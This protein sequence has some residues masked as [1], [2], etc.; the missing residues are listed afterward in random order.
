MRIAI[1][2]HG[3]KLNRAESDQLAQALVRAGHDVVTIEEDPD[4]YILNTCT[5]T[6]V[7]DSKARQALR[8]ARRRVP[9]VMTLP[10]GC[11]A[12]RAAGELLGIEGVARVVGGVN[13]QQVL[14]AL[15]EM[16]K[17]ICPRDGL[18]VLAEMKERQH[19]RTRAFIK[20]QSG[21]RHACS[22]CIVRCIKGS[23]VS[24]PVESV[25]AQVRER[26]SEGYREVV[27]TGTQPGSYGRDLNGMSLGALVGRILDETGVPRVRVSS[28]LPH[29]IDS[30]LLALMGDGRLCPHV[31]VPLQS[32]SASVLRRM[33]RP[34]TLGSFATA[35]ERLR[36]AASRMAVTT[37]VIVGFPGET[38]GEFEESLRFCEEMG[39]ARMHVFSFSPRPGTPASKMQSRYE[40]AERR[41]RMDRMLA[42]ARAIEERFLLRWVS[43][44]CPV[45]WEE[46]R[47]VSGRAVWSGLTDN[48]LRVY[49]GSSYDLT[50]QI[51][52]A[53]LLRAGD[54]ALWAEVLPFSV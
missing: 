48:Y 54:G 30:T 34:Y 22:Y 28:L 1:E 10:I 29:E 35:V 14:S 25:L 44:T 6:H 46:K 47:E 27:L 50:N 15:A 52:D 13:S 5:V 26:V 32:G 21:C 9:G 39:F 20:V 16:E 40:A 17:S 31:H 42:L 49:T 38:E 45:L 8:A 43:T 23:P 3:C 11:Y 4:I 51:T 33:R 24:V 37:D 19:G 18:S 53:R 36:G 2:T 41:M 12:Q 7:A